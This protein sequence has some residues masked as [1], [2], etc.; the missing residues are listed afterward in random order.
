[1]QIDLFDTAEFIRKNNLK[2][3]SDPMMFIKGSI[4]SPNGLISTD[5]FGVSM[6]E[7]KSTFAYIDLHGYFLHPYIYKL[8][9]R[10]NRNFES[11]VHGSKKFIIEN[12]NIVENEN[13][14]TGLDFLYKNWE[15]LNFEGD[16]GTRAIRVNVLKN[17]TKKEIFTHYWI[18]IPAFYR[19]VNFENIDSGKI[20]HRSEVND[21]YTKLIRLASIVN[22]EGNFDFVLISTQAKIQDTLVELYD[23]F[24]SK[25]SKKEGMFR[26]NLLGKSVDYGSRCVI[27]APTFHANTP[28]EMTIDYYHCGVPLAHCCSL[29]N[30]FIIAWVRNFFRQQFETS[31]NKIPYKNSK[32]EISFY[33]VDDPELYFT[34][35]Y[36]KKEIDNFI[37]NFHDR[38]KII[39]V[40]VKG[41]EKSVPFTISTRQYVKGD[42]IS[43]HSMDSR[44]ATWCDILYQAAVD[45]TENKCVYITRYPIGDYFSI[46]PNKVF[47]M[48]T[49]ETVPMYVG[50]RVYEH[51]PKIDL[52]KSKQEV[53]TSFIDTVRMSNLYL[54]GLGG[55]YDGDQISIRGVFTQEANEEA[56]KQMHSKARILSIYTD[57]VRISTNES[58]QTLYAMTK[59]E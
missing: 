19:D 38:F 56:L 30:P 9:K 45:V 23:F 18:V 48:S 59:F 34:D 44:P 28:S 15:K 24:K 25:L 13:G 33:E 2:E 6:S 54:K 37:K 1:M 58:I 7:R 3:V 42:P 10:L 4:P 49:S 12:G 57:N 53:S 21:K 11:L 52:T 14:E 40:P 8:L 32:G 36:I 31:G 51:Y 46:F 35:E 20:S 55:D 41:E 5:I 27:S 17:Y 16:V 22:T 26:R 50:N 29:F 39:M 43:E 47:V